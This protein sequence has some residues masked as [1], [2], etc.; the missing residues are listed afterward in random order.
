[1]LTYYTKRLT[2]YLMGSED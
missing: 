1:L 2:I